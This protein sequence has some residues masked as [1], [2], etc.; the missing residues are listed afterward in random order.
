[1]GNDIKRYL[2]VS[3][4]GWHDTIFQELQKETEFHWI[5]YTSRNE[6]TLENLNKIQPILIFIPHWSYIIPSEIY[7]E[8]ECIVFHM[9]DL[10][11]GRGGSPLQNLIIRGF[12][13]TRISAIRIAAGID[14]GPIY[15][16]AL[17]K[18]DG[19]AQEI[20]IRSAEVIK[21]M[22]YDIIYKK[23]VPLEQEGEVTLFKRRKPHE[24]NIA[25][26]DSISKVYDYIRMLDADGYPQAFLETEYFRF[27]FSNGCMEDKNA[28]KANVRIIKK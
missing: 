11:F 8:F 19:S 9:T 17:L 13:E 22:I 23:L 6:F 25:N 14:A 1:M 10:P 27:E 18:L 24:S 16:K 20:F 2:F 3:E 5:R 21:S 7:T 15:L 26:L 28:I 12:K 4:K